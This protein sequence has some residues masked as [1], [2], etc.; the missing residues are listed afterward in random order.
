MAKKKDMS[1]YVSGA[2]GGALGSGRSN[3]GLGSLRGAM[4]GTTRQ[5]RMNSYLSTATG[6]ASAPKPA[7][8]KKGT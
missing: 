8:K 2:V 4:N 6:E 3:L 5:N 7:K 1:G